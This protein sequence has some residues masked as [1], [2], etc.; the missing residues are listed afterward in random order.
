MQSMIGTTLG[1]FRVVEIL[2]Q[3]AL[4]ITFRA[5]QVSTRRYVALSAIRPPYLHDPYLRREF[6]RQVPLLRKLA[7]PNIPPIYQAADINGWI[8][9][10]ARIP[11]VTSLASLAGKPQRLGRVVD[12]VIQ[13]GAALDQAHGV[14][15]IH[16]GL[17]PAN[18]RLAEGERV[19]VVGFG[20]YSLA[21]ASPSLLEERVTG[22]WPEYLAPEQ[23]RSYGA[24]IRSD[25]FSFGVLIYTLMFGAPPFQGA[26]PDEVAAQHNLLPP[27]P[28]L[29]NP[30]ITPNMEEIFR[31]A[32]A[33]NAVFRYGTAGQLTREFVKAAESMLEIE[34]ARETPL[35]S[36]LILP[37]RATAPTLAYRADEP[38]PPAVAAEPTAP[39]TP[40]RRL[41]LW[42][43][44]AAAGAFALGILLAGALL[45]ALFA[46]GVVRLR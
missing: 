10:A 27:S 18:V 21:A 12:L 32:L 9:V 38:A 22:Q 1:D 33:K 45:G 25:V 37:S 15:L 29:L 8:V 44:L 43:G 40:R 39:A 28:R 4:T 19:A 35:P 6:Q 42:V 23:A 46:T 16:G 41:A 7:H 3:D 26:T 34:A 2:T 11:P 24:N 14:G 31:R 13:L 20:A 17:N 30:Y 5:Y 36:P